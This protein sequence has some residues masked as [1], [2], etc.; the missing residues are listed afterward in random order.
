YLHLLGGRD[1][2]GAARDFVDLGKSGPEQ[3]DEQDETDPAQHRAGAQRLLADLRPFG[4]GGPVQV[5]VGLFRNPAR[6]QAIDEIAAD[7]LVGRGAEAVHDFFRARLHDAF[8]MRPC[9][10]ASTTRSFGPSATILPLSITIRRS[11]SSSR[12]VRWVT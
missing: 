11:T 12:L 10:S 9:L 4:I 6:E 8:S 3:E 7:A 1:L 5:L 2:G